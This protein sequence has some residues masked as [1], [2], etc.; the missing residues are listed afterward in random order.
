MKKR[1]FVPIL[2]RVKQG[3]SI[4][5]ICKTHRINF[6]Q[7]AYLNPQFDMFGYRNPDVIFPDE[8][9]VVGRAIYDPL[10]FTKE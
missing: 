7:F 1:Q 4:L 5:M 3:D 10:M 2:Y 9:F 8:I 6:T